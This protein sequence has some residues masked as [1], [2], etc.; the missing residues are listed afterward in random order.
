M[1]VSGYVYAMY[2]GTVRRA[3]WSLCLPHGLLRALCRYPRT[4]YIG[5][6][7]SS[8]WILVLFIS[9]ILYIG[10]H[11]IAFLA[12]VPKIPNLMHMYI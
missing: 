1:Y 6:N 12:S 3:T 5:S 7:L 11:S 2:A 8:F 10:T 4:M 9:R